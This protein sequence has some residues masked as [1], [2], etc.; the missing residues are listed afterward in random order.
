MVEKVA[1]KLTVFIVK[2][3]TDDSHFVALEYIGHR[4]PDPAFWTF[5]EFFK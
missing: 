2:A 4:E 3:H 1:I 5:L